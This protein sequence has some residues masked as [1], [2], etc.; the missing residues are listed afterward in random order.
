MEELEKYLLTDLSE[1]VLSYLDTETEIF[2]S[3]FMISNISCDLL[4]YLKRKEK[5][6]FGEKYFIWMFKSPLNKRSSCHEKLRG[7]IRQYIKHKYI[8]FY[9]KDYHNTFFN[10]EKFKNML[11]EVQDKLTEGEP[12]YS[13]KS[14]WKFF[15]LGD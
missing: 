8:W 11:C 1:I 15:R 2:I 14:E 10:H 9:D 3:D 4:K 6:R 7:S 5:K 12:V 13:G